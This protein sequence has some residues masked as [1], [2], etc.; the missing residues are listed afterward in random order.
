MK[1]MNEFMTT[2]AAAF[3]ATDIGAYFAPIFRP[4]ITGQ[5]RLHPIR[6]RPATY[7]TN[8]LRA[9]QGNSWHRQRT[10]L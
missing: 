8:L 9:S 2:I 6:V 3:Q 7:E 1:T 4:M 10:G 5:N